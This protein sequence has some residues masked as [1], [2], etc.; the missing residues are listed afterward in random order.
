MTIASITKELEKTITRSRLLEILQWAR[1]SGEA[2]VYHRVSYLL[3]QEPKARKFDLGLG[4]PFIPNLGSIE[5]SLDQ[6]EYLPQ[7][8]GMPELDLSDIYKTINDKILKEINENGRLPFEKPWIDPNMLRGGKDAYSLFLSYSTNKPYSIANQMLIAQ[9]LRK[10]KLDHPFFITKEAVKKKGGKISKDLKPVIIYVVGYMWVYDG[11]KETV[12]KYSVNSIETYLK[13]LGFSGKELADKMDNALRKFLTTN[14]VYPTDDVTGIEFNFK[15]R[16]YIA[17]RAG[18]WQDNIE[19]A[20]AIVEA[21]PTENRIVINHKKQDRAYYSPSDDAVF[22][23]VKDQF[24][25]PERYYSTLF[26]EIVHATGSPQRINRLKGGF[27]FNPEYNKE[28]LVAEVGASYLTAEAGILN[29]H[30]RHTASYLKNYLQALKKQLG[31]DPEYMLRAFSEAQRAAEYLLQRNSNGRPLYAVRLLEKLE[32]EAKDNAV[33]KV[34]KTKSHRS[35]KTKNGTIKVAKRK[36][37]ATKRDQSALNRKK[38]PEAYFKGELKKEYYFDKDGKLRHENDELFQELFGD[39][40]DKGFSKNLETER[41]AIQTRKNGKL[42]NRQLDLFNDMDIKG[43]AAPEDVVRD[44]YVFQ[45]YILKLKYEKP[46]KQKTVHVGDVGGKLAKLTKASTISMPGRIIEDQVNKHP[47]GALFYNLMDL[48]RCIENTSEIDQTGKTFTV[49]CDMINFSGGTYKARVKLR[50]NGKRLDVVDFIPRLTRKQYRVATEPQ[51]PKKKR[52][53]K[54]VVKK[55]AA[56]KPKPVKKAA[57]KK[58]VKKP[59]QK[60]RLASPIPNVPIEESV[61]QPVPVIMETAPDPK[62]VQNDLAELIAQNKEKSENVANIEKFRMPNELEPFLG[63]LERYRLAIVLIGESGAFKS[64]MTAQIMDG[65]LKLGDQVAYFPLEMGGLHAAPTKNALERNVSNYQAK[66]DSGQLTIM[67]Y[68]SNGVD[69]I[70][71]FAATGAFNTIVIDSWTELDADS[72]EFNELRKDFPNVAF[73]VIFQL[74]AQGKIRGGNKPVFD[75]PVRIMCFKGEDKNDIYQ[76]Y[77]E[78]MKN[79]ENETGLKYLIAKKQML[80]APSD[81]SSTTEP[82]QEYSEVKNSWSD[83]PLIL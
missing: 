13:E 83:V 48:A 67:D 4:R 57:V 55:K 28:E 52:K 63:N 16:E 62:P 25:K 19:A 75:A 69:T 43:L 38:H 64:Q 78:I 80:N 76:N 45:N 26:H 44:R 73:V 23:P 82:T 79:R 50:E 20:E 72:R 22:M 1:E 6:Y 58:I 18:Q 59:V 35:K 14:E 10:R 17:G 46:V 60:S 9:Q 11:P 5:T 54:T 2:D 3:D 49:Y 47:G 27:K 77:A 34:K 29:K 61:S 37:K 56:S 8:L 68:A 32:K 66:I 21:R 41:K 71:Q 30:I 12:F 74:N 65:F 31:D 24:P 36:E 40:G 42:K 7:G 53:A 70:R 51:K 39:N 33:A 15:D 81:N